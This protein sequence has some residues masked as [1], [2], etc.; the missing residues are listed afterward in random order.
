DTGLVPG[1]SPRRPRA[2]VPVSIASTNAI[3]ASG[4]PLL[5]ST[6]SASGL[7]APGSPNVRA[8]FEQRLRRIEQTEL[9][10]LMRAHWGGAFQIAAVRT[11]GPISAIRGLGATP[12]VGT[13][14]RLNSN[15]RNGCTNEQARGSRVAAVSN[16][17]IV[18]V[19]SSAPAGGFT[20]AEYQSIAVTFDTLIFPLDTAAF[21]K[22]SDMDSNGRIVLFFTT[23]VNQ[24]TPLNTPS[25][26]GFIGGFFFPRDLFP[27]TAT[28]AVGACATSNEGEMF[29]LPVVDPN[30]Q[31][32]VFFKDKAALLKST[33]G[34]LA[35]EFQHLINAS[36][37]IYVT[38]ANVDFMD[39]WLNEGM[40]HLAEELLYYRVTGFAPKQNLNLTTVAGTQA[41]LDAINAYQVQNLGRLSTYMKDPDINS[42]YVPNDSLATRGATWE[43]LRYVLDMAPNPASTYLHALVDSPISVPPLVPNDPEPNGIPIFNSVFGSVF[44]DITVAVRQQVIAQFFDDTGVPIDPRYSFPSWNFRSILPQINKDAAGT[45]RFPL[46]IKSLVDGSPAAFSLTT[47]GSGYA[48]FGVS[49]STIAGITP[50]SAGGPVPALVQLILVRTK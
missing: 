13:P 27:R 44:A 32:N 7:G 5:A 43:L 46:A 15:G 4:P 3:A 25:T 21:G 49:G 18:V 17:A 42:P 40:S 36:R 33:I 35:H 24:L 1:S 37:R 8:A 22:P 12:T 47:G 38:T 30:G 48:R 16:T 41:R 19:D 23:A 9:R 26:S 11:P 20:D 28:A 6:A 2:S 14:I 31:F 45:P 10:P 39:T 29:Y 34:T 50:T